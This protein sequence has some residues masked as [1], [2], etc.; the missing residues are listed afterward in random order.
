MI[1]KVIITLKKGATHLDTATSYPLEAS[2]TA[3]ILGNNYFWEITF[4]YWHYGAHHIEV[5]PMYQTGIYSIS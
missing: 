5:H 3:T 4:T 2:F 1:L